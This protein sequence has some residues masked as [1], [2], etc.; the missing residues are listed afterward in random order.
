MTTLMISL[1]AV[2]VHFTK[3]ILILSLGPLVKRSSDYYNFVI[4]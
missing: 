3:L 1:L 2:Y 4:N